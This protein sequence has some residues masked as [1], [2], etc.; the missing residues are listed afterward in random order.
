[1][2]DYKN[3][4]LIDTRELSDIN[5]TAFLFEHEKTKAKVLKLSNDDENKVFSIAFKTIPQDS[6]GVAHIMEHS[7]LNGSKKYTTREPFMDLVKSSLQTFLNAITYP[8][9]T[10]YPVASRNA[11]DFKN[12]VDVY[13]DAVFNPIV[14]EKKNIF[15]QEGWHYEIKNVDD[16]IKYNGV[17]Y[18][19]M[20][21]SY[22]SIY[23][24]IFD[25]LFKYLYP[26]TTYAHSSGGNPYNI[27]DLT[28]EKFLE[29]HDKYYHPS[30]SFIYFY[31]NGNIEEE[32]DHLS[33]YLDEYDYKKIDSDIPYQKPFEKTKKVQV[34]Y[35]ISKDENP[36]G[37]DVLVYAA[38]VGH[39]TNVK[40]AF[41]STILSDVLFSNESAIIKEKLLQENIC[42]SVE[43][44]SSYGQEITMGV[45]A[46]N[47]DV[48]N[49][50]K[51]E[52][53]VK[54]ELEN[55]VKNGID[56]DELTSTL[57]KL[58]YDLKEAGSFHTKGV[59]YFLKSALSFMYSDSYYD[60]LQFSET[61]AECIPTLE[62][63]D[64]DAKLEDV[65]R[66][67]KKIDNYTFLNPNLFTSNIHYASFMFDLS[68]FSQKDYFY[69]SL[70]SDYIGL[71]DTT[72][73]D[74]K[75]LYT[76]TY[77]ASGGIFTAIHLSNTK[78]NQDLKTN[79]V[80]SFKTI[81]K[82]EDECIKILEEYL[83]N[84]KFEDKNRFKNILQN[85]KQEYK[86]RILEAGNQ[87][88]LTRSMASFSE[89]SV[90]EDEC[91]GISYYEKLCD[92]L[93]DF[94]EKSDITLKKLKDYY[95]KI[96]NSNDMIVSIIN[97]QESANKFFDKLQKSL[98]A[99]M[100]TKDINIKS[101]PTK[102]FKL[103]EAYKTSSNVNYVVKSA[104]LKK[105]GFEY[106]SKITVLTNILNTSF[107]YNEVRAKGGAY[108]VGMS[109]S[110]N[111]ILYVYS[112]RDPNIKNTIDIY[113]QIDKFVENMSFDEK[114]MKQFIIG[115]VN[116]FNPPMTTFTKGS[117]SIN[118]YLSG[119]TIED[120]ENYLEN[121]LHTTVDDLKKFAQII[122]KAMKENHLVV[123]G[124]D[125][126][127]DEDANLFDKIINVE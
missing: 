126:K 62:L 89:K 20:K 14:Y 75:K 48:K 104:D 97:E 12:L 3:F 60:Q 123:V 6:T 24:I 4:K 72:N 41:V 105:Y 25:E 115:T 31:G 121:M 119:R 82:T 127:I 52:A 113:D 88:A 19:E 45:I 108:G 81:E 61:L 103:K 124:N 86:T 93:N 122:K 44:V 26:D 38:N 37:K 114:E 117:R 11:K 15:Y 107:L 66:I 120:Y 29:F 22:S 17:V 98:I 118:M 83:F 92:V 85:L 101:S 69:L 76:Q 32:L 70:L 95:E 27:P 78:N 34:E 9:K 5:S 125:I 91:S 90:L 49:T 87:I 67:E 106:N 65:E 53:L 8:D 102:F 109:V 58:E 21:G 40:D 23:T 28:Y 94:D 111:G 112:Y 42:E 2:Q 74:Y 46:E 51:F 77:L 73:Y 13:L 43:N 64:I 39:I 50:E 63:S 68:K 59:I 16:D 33:E 80:F 100:N 116:Q 35:N 99:K 54:R 36:D 96:V 7:V 56:K 57:N 18:N 79:F 84:V 10:C 47:S 30:N 110:L 1:M 71:S 55:I